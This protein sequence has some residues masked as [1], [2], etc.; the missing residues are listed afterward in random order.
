V[1]RK[2]VVILTHEDLIPPDDVKGLSEQEFLKF[3]REWGVADAL[4]KMRNIVRFVGVSHDLTP[5][6]S[7]VEGWK[8]DVLFNLLMEFQDVGPY[9]VHV[10]AYLELLNT[11][12][13]GCNP[14]GILLARDKALCKKILRFHRIPTPAFAVYRRGQRV[15]ARRDL[16]FPLIV[17]SVDEEASYGIAQASVVSDVKQLA[18][19]VA[20]IIVSVV[21]DALV[22]EYV[23]GRE[24]TISVIGNDR[25]ATFPIWELYFDDLPEGT[26]PIATAKVK[27][28]VAYQKKLGIRTGK[29]DPM[30]EEDARRIARLARRV[31]RVLGLSGYARLDLRV[32]EADRVYVI[33]ANATPDITYDEDFAESAEAA[34]IP[35]P[36]LLQRIIRLATAYEPHWKRV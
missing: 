20:L 7:I 34:G 1:S 8:P 16:P 12:Y 32:S 23:S 5:I 3:K 24:L 13:T 26:L 31:Y 4:V 2:R 19:R 25:L 36:K 11:A 22:E 27:W 28:D 18:E 17:K 15:R 6:R 21:T 33:E 30:S 9:Q 29:A 10:T 35:Y 14:A